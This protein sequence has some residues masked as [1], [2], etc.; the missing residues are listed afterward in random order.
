MAPKVTGEV[1]KDMGFGGVMFVPRALY[2]TSKVGDMLV[3]VNT[4]YD[5][6]EPTLVSDVQAFDPAIYHPRMAIA[7]ALGVLFGLAGW[8]VGRRLAPRT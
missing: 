4:P 3:I 1:L 7:S 2:D 6:E 8:L 5:P